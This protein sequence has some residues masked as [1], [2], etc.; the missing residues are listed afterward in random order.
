MVDFQLLAKETQH[1]PWKDVVTKHLGEGTAY[2]WSVSDHCAIAPLLAIPEQCERALVTHCHSGT[3]PLALSELCQTVYSTDP[4]K[5]A[6]RFTHLRAHQSNRTNVITF[7]GHP[8]RIFKANSFDLIVTTFPDTEETLKTLLNL[9][10]PNGQLCISC[11]NASSLKNRSQNPAQ[12]KTKFL[13]QLERL[14]LTNIQTYAAYPDHLN[15]NTLIHTEDKRAFA[16]LQQMPFIR[17]VK[18]TLL[19]KI[20]HQLFV[21]LLAGGFWYSATHAPLQKHN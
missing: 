12:T 17:H 20:T 8:H 16:A 19:K 9:L 4:N 3:Y 13:R 5:H 21:R 10:S 1:H 7:M 2:A 18:T 14:S 11:P 15:V 6:A